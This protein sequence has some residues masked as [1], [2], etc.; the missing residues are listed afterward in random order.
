MG[1]CEFSN[2]KIVKNNLE[3]SNF[4]VTDYMLGAN[5]LQ[6]KILF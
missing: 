3:I 4:F 6:L 2:E 1:F 5:E